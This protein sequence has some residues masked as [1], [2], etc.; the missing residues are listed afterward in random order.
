MM[1]HS[2]VWKLCDFKVLKIGQN[3][4]ANNRTWR[5][6]AEPVT[7]IQL[8]EGYLML[9]LCLAKEIDQFWGID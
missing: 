8:H 3:L 9:Y 1:L 7:F 2:V 5:V 4:H 6:F